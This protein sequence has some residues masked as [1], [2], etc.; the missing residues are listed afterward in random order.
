MQST[1]FQEFMGNLAGDRRV[2]RLVE[3]GVLPADF[4]TKGPEVAVLI[5]A[6]RLAD[7]ELSTPHREGDSNRAAR[8]RLHRVFSLDSPRLQELEPVD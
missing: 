4:A 1:T 8:P 6:M 7:R 5:L 2:R 3:R